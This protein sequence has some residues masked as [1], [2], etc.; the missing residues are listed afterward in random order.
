MTA[1]GQH[2]VQ[3]VKSSGQTKAEEGRGMGHWGPCVPS[4]E[5]SG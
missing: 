5:W 2:I 1:T 4:G 3:K